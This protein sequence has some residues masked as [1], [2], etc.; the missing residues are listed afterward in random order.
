MSDKIADYTKSNQGKLS[1]SEA[2]KAQTQPHPYD[3]TAD[4]NPEA[5]KEQINEEAKK[6]KA[7]SSE[8]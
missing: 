3:D 4:L 8:K 7:K 1:S 2:L 5:T 6:V